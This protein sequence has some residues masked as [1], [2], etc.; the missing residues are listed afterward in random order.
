[1]RPVLV[2]QTCIHFRW[3][4]TG[5]YAGAHSRGGSGT[6]VSSFTPRLG[7]QWGGS[8]Q[9][10]QVAYLEEVRKL[11]LRSCYH[12]GLPPCLVLST[13][14]KCSFVS[15]PYHTLV[16]Y[17]GEHTDTERR[18]TWQIHKKTE[19]TCFLKESDPTTELLSAAT[20]LR[21]CWSRVFIHS[22]YSL[23]HT[24]TQTHWP[25]N[26]S[27]FTQS[28]NTHIRTRKC[29]DTHK[30]LQKQANRRTCACLDSVVSSSVAEFKEFEMTGCCHVR[31]LLVKFGPTPW[32]HFNHYILFYT[33]FSRS[34]SNH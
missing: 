19:K 32:A 21:L 10:T 2:K 12:W 4:T 3:I 23:Q 18:Y 9:S 8:R 1:M 22:V 33:D 26:F 5:E 17:P 15:Q 31:L 24:F 25:L 11:V 27:H 28:Q 6:F 34:Y 14:P 29:T 30:E 7:A 16:F 20:R 13:A